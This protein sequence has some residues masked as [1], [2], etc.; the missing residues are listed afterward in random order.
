MPFSLG[1]T[2]NIQMEICAFGGEDNGQAGARRSRD[3][4]ALAHLPTPPQAHTDIWM[5]DVE[6]SRKTDHVEMRI[7]SVMLDV[8]S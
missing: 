7:L 6:L 3:A 4:S 5:L 8:G 2:S 1:S